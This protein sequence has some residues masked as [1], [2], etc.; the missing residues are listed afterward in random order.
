MNPKTNY[1][2][3][4]KSSPSKIKIAVVITILLL[5]NDLVVACLSINDPR[6][7]LGAIMV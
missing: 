4:F 7:V 5:L 1:I 3:L 2:K 6:A